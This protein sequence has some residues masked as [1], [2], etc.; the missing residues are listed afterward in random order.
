M[1]IKAL[2]NFNHDQLGRVSKGQEVEITPN[3]LSGIKHLVS[4]YE[5]KVIHEEPAEPKKP[6][7]SS[8]AAPASPKPTARKSRFGRSKK[9]ES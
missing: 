5:T 2:K 1:R 4:I 3:Q 9:T 7:S 8:P 6:V